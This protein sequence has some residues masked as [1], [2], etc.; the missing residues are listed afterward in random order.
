MPLEKTADGVIRR[1]NVLYFLE[2]DN[3]LLLL[4]YH[5]MLNTETFLGD[6]RKR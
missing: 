5:K 6:I 3:G 4:V 1:D 2:P